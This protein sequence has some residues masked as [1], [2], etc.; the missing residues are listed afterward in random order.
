MSSC[1][2][3]G[4]WSA[5]LGESGGHR[6][7]LPG[8][9]GSLGAFPS[10]GRARR[11]LK[12]RQGSP[13]ATPQGL[14]P[15]SRTYRPFPPRRATPQD[16]E[17]AGCSGSQ[18]RPLGVSGRTQVPAGKQPRHLGQT[19][20]G[21]R[22]GSRGDPAPPSGDSPAHPPAPAAAPRAPRHRGPTWPQ[23][24]ARPTPVAQAAPPRGASAASPG[25]ARKRPGPR[26]G[27]QPGGVQE[28]NPGPDPTG[29]QEPSPP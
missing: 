15:R 29:G 14:E 9:G 23:R 12:Q 13:A 26:G 22:E 17:D 8:S 19:G 25:G 7:S 18:V 28:G 2:F 21:L 3:T 4:K 27:P 24:P 20:G 11:C 1:R 16:G 6:C 5:H 10:D